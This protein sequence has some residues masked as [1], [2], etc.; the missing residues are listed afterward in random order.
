MVSA[1]SS[2]GARV[3]PA[4]FA[5]TGFQHADEAILVTDHHHLIVAANPR[6]VELTGK[7]LDALIGTTLEAA[8]LEGRWLVDR[9]RFLAG[10]ES[11]GRAR[12]EVCWRDAQGQERPGLL[13]AR[14]V[15]ESQRD[16]YQVLVLTDLACLAV[17]GGAPSAA[18]EVYFDNLTGLPN[19]QLV[20]QLI[21]ESVQHAR[22]HHGQLAICALDLDHFKDHNDQLGREVGDLL[23][24]TFAQ[25]ITHLMGGDD[26]VARVGGDEF[27]LLIHGVEGDA[28]YQQLLDAIEA[29][30]VLQGHSVRLT[31]SLGVTCFPEDT[32]EGD[33]LLRHA[34]Q[35]MYR[36]KQRGRNAFHRFD[37][38]QDR[39]LQVRQQQRTRLAAGLAQGEL[40]LH[41]QP[42]VDLFDGSV[43]GVEALV[44]WQHPDEG[45][46]APGAFLPA[47]TGS[48]LEQALGEWVLEAALQQIT[49]WQGRSI[50]LPVHVNISPA[51][52][53]SDTFVSGLEALLSRYP[54]VS[55][56]LLKLEIL[57]ST[58]IHDV[59][60]A[61]AT[62][63]RC[64]A[65]G[66]DFA[67]DDFGTGFSSLTHLRQLPVDLIKIDQSFVRDML[68]DPDDLAIVES[69]IFMANRFKR[70]M[71]AE[72]VE[73]LA[74]ARALVRL[75]CTLAQGYGIARPMPAEALAEW[76][77]GWSARHEWRALS[78]Q[79]S[80]PG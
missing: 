18:R 27:V 2:A 33:V 40:R 23:L 66:I 79:A 76:L 78:L 70:P 71:L 32:G 25:R 17:S 61:L 56:R 42:Q 53:L 14:R 65:M 58:A 7:P 72:G 44:R 39:E 73:T 10:L 41:Y 67:I 15:Q 20:T 77:E 5:E 55:P 52:L 12:A 26:V 75:G 80:R 63:C 46:L 16:P 60:K 36:A 37:P 31:A 74:H 49:E 43:V 22:R 50:V 30:L 38:S 9:P 64:Q 8:G 6:F 1:L 59:Q 48:Y 69:V 4:R 45:L 54:G 51:H 11:T 35:A 28:L 21:E 68:S 57:E 13:S 34:T 19:Q 62:M 47:I 29:P 24:A 3:F